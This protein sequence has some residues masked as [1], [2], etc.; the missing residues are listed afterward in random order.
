[1]EESAAHRSQL[2]ENLKQNHI[3]YRWKVEKME[4]SLLEVELHNPARSTKPGEAV[5]L[6]L[7]RNQAVSSILLLSRQQNNK[8][9]KIAFLQRCCQS[10][11][12]GFLCFITANVQ[13]YPN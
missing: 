6:I 11:S 7:K 2:V 9:I 4:G 1:M 10:C 12:C 8:A 13:Y 3:E 5:V